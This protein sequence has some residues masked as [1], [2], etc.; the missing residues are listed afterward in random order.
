MFFDNFMTFAVLLNT[1]ALAINHYGISTEVETI[2]NIFND[3][4]TQIFIVEMAMKLLAAQISRAVK[5]PPSRAPGE[6]Q[7]QEDELARLA[8]FV[9]EPFDPNK[10]PNKPFTG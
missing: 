10:D 7:A 4:F 1:I 5:P 3:Y 6:D 2:L 8:D 9:L